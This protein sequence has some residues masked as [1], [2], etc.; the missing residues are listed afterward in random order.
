MSTAAVL[1]HA[2]A[3]L[4]LEERPAPEP[5]PG[6]VLIR[7][8]ACG[9]CHSDLH[10]QEGWFP[11]TRWPVVPGH[12]VAGIIEAV[13][14]GVE[15]PEAGTRVGVPW[16]HD[17]CGHCA[18]CLGGDEVLCPEREV[19]G[20]SCDGGYQELMLA[21][22]AFATPLP[23]GLSFREAAPLLCAGLTVWG[24]IVH[25]GFK[26]D[27]RVAVIGLGGLGEL[28]VRYVAAMG[29]RVAVIS[30]SAAKADEAR[31]LGAELY[32]DAGAGDPADALR[33]WGG[34]GADLVLA[35]A[36]SAELAQ[37]AF[38]G[39]APNGTLVM[40]GL[41]AVPIAVTARDLIPARRRL[42]GST[43][44]TRRELRDC[45]A[46]AAAHDVRPQ[47]TTF[48]LGDANDVWDRLRDGRLRGR[49]V[50]EPDAS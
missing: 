5:G 12:E 9:V 17:S 4:E 24:G 19:T 47:V 44:G 8:A 26:A 41:D 14:E 35:T 46:F 48:G 22:A 25:G 39:L 21:P 13:G 15:W 20:V 45:L 50:L 11:Y 42:M 23:D 34:G 36:P 3:P 30:R 49:A 2:N 37:A 31:A 38:P 6:Q 40:L 43:T 27:D 32:V 28:A 1:S 33:R 29:G 18:W 10:L 16:L 7:V